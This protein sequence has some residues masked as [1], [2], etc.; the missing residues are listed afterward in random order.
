MWDERCYVAEHRRVVIPRHAV[1]VRLQDCRAKMVF[2]LFGAYMPGRGLKESTVRK[3]W[4]KLTEAVA[5]ADTGKMVVGDIN[6]ELTSA[7]QR[8]GRHPTI[9]DGLLQRLV[10][11]ELLVEAVDWIRRPMSAQG[12]RVR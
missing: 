12:A 7:L 1:E 2:T 10:G 8:E 9:A 5:D 6:A 3:A 4:E 11:D